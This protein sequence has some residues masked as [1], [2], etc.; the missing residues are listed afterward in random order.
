[1]ILLGSQLSFCMEAKEPHELATCRCSAPGPSW[2]LSWQL[3]PPGR[4]Q[5]AFGLFQPA[6]FKLSELMPGEAATTLL[7]PPP[8]LGLW[9]WFLCF[10]FFTFRQSFIVFFHYYLFLFYPLPPPPI[11]LPPAITTLLIVIWI[12]WLWFCFEP[13]GV[14]YAAMR[15]W[16]TSY[17]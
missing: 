12:Y 17:H 1:M 5:W 13:L 14:G 8:I 11:P 6:G 10:Y 9:C 15:D 3:Q 4:L 7:G 16:N 2:C